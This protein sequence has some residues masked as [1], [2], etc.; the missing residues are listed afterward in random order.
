[1]LGGLAPAARVASARERAGSLL[2]RATALVMSRM[3]TDHRRVERLTSRLPVV[4]ASR[5]DRARASLDAAAAALGALGPQATLDRGYAIVRRA[6]DGSVVRRPQDAPP[7]TALAV[8]L[9][10]GDLAATVDAGRG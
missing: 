8:R 2:E 10:G 9:A 4:A 3:D 1:M 5:L 6:L 7:G